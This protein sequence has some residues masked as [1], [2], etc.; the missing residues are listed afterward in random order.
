MTK[1]VLVGLVAIGALLL[2]VL[3]LLGSGVLGQ[4]WG[5]GEVQ[6]AAL[7]A[8][9]VRARAERQESGA[10]G[11]GRAGAKQILFGDLH[12]HST[13]SLDAFLMALPMAGGEGAHPVAAACDFA[14]Y[15]SQ[16]DFWSI[17]DH[18]MAHSPQTWSETVD[19]V[20]Q[21]DATA[22]PADP[23]LVSFLGWEW[24]QMGTRPENHYGHKNVVLKDLEDVPARAI[25]ARPPP[26][27]IDR[28]RDGLPGPLT[29]GL[30]GVV[31]PGRDTLDAIRYFREMLADP[32]CP[33]GVPVRELPVAC[34]ESAATPEDLYAKLDDWGFPALVIPHGTTWGYYTPQGSSW[35]KQLTP[36]QHDP[37]YQ[38]LIEVFSGHGNSEELRDWREVIL[39]PDGRRSCPEPRDDFLPS[40]RRAGEII[41]E[42]CLAAG[43]SEAECDE[44]A[45]EARQHYV[46]ADTTG[47]LTVPGVTA[48]DWLDSGQCRDCFQPSFN[49]R[50]RSSVQYILALGRP[51]APAGVRR[52]DLGFIASSD[53]HSARPGTGYKEYARTEMTEARLPIA[54][55]A[56]IPRREVEPEPRSRP[57]D[58]AEVGG[59]FF[60]QR[61]AERAAS[62]FLTG[63]LAAVHAEGRSREAI[64][65]AFGRK[66]VYGTSG[67]RILLWFDLLNPPGS[68]GATLPMGGSTR[69]A[70]SPI[71]QVRAVGSL[72]QRP[73][74]PEL[75]VRGLEPE[76]LERLCKGECFHPSER[77]RLITRIEVVRI[78][79][80]VRPDEAIDGLVEDPWRV[81][82]CEP[83]P[84]GCV[85]TFTDPELGP[86][87]R[88][89]LYYVRAIE[90]PS[91]AV[92]ADPLGCT[93]DER[94]RCVAL[95]ACIDRPDDDE[96]LAPTE[97]RAWSSPIFVEWGGGGR[98]GQNARHPETA[99]LSASAGSP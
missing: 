84:A 13:F 35:D 77:R 20:R 40:C 7:P 2:G 71:F 27:A 98:D 25:G 41:A 15:C 5:P 48:A 95:D 92:G 80:Q 11:V 81:L 66:E 30:L 87:A 50:P 33:D 38:G 69:I 91:L 21:C 49:Y 18:A 72:E 9:A 68:S 97:E 44:R 46:D 73:G 70:E 57:F 82:P 22:D 1:R 59:S 24:T 90:E 17:N 83:D 19:S 78:R 23:D 61:E 39:H 88:D 96:C 43:E 34:K 86:S 28:Q 12:V 63:G 67:P 6:G 31:R 94:G 54:G 53:V 32:D 10:G 93:R 42:R 14:R 75:A 58:A 29:L 76:R 99:P 62:F 60:S 55:A 85:V 45:A 52:F 16:I 26:D 64:W 74:C 56:V 8:E 36:A 37:R 3:A 89:A 4:R 51:D 65:D 47:H 79:P